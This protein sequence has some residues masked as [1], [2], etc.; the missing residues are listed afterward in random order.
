M[1]SVLENLV[2]K[3][4]TETEA[5][6]NYLLKNLGDRKLVMQMFKE[7]GTGFKD[8]VGGYLRIVRLGI[9]RADGTE[10]ARLEWT[11]PLIKEEKTVK[12][13]NG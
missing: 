4:K 5:N 1:K 13:T 3:S 8:R 2:E 11:R 6:K 7:V 9:Y 10:S 12:K